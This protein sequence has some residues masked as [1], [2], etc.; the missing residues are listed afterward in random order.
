[1]TPKVQALKS[2]INKQIGLHE[3]K[4]T[5]QKKFNKIKTIESGKKYLYMIY[6]IIG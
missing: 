2:K 3:S 4:S 6:L 5:K 1:M